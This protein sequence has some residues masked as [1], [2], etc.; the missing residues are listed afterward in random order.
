MQRFRASDGAEIA[1]DERG[2]GDAARLLFVHGWQADHTVWRDMIAALEP[3]VRT[4]AVDLRGSGESRDARAPFTLERFAQ[5]LR[6]MIDALAIAPIFV[7]GHSMGA[8]V[9]LRLAVDAPDRVSALALIAP[10]PASGAG[11]TPK[12]ADYLRG[13]AGNAQAARKWLARTFAGE[14]DAHML[15][16]VCT[17]A[18]STPRESALESFESWANAD[19]AEATKAIRVPTVVIAPEHDTPETHERKVAS[20]IPGARYVVLPNAGHYA[21]LEQPQELAALIF[22]NRKGNDE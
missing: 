17:A 21:I 22:N 15:D 20:L 10:V 6:E 7:V 13:T 2:P 9:A 5:D 19:F 11:F 8:T 14:P 16:R 18:A 1:Y 4:F 12:G 3:E